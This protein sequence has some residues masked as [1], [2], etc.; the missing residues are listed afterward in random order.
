MTVALQLTIDG[1]EVPINQCQ[2]GFTELQRR[3]IRQARKT[4]ITTLE[5]GLMAH[6]KRGRCAQ[7]GIKWDTWTGRGRQC[8]PYCSTDGAQALKRLVNRGVLKKISK[9]TYTLEER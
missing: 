1:R 3:I 7:T 2:I 4:G 6:Q 8:C 5:A 9:G